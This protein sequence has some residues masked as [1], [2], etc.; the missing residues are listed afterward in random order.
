MQDNG[1]CI[2]HESPRHVFNGKLLEHGR[3]DGLYEVLYCPSSCLLWW[4]SGWIGQIYT[5][6]ATNK[7]AYCA[8]TRICVR[9]HIDYMHYKARD[10]KAITGHLIVF[11]KVPRPWKWD[12]EEAEGDRLFEDYINART[13][14][15]REETACPVLII[16]SCPYAVWLPMCR[17]AWY[18]TRIYIIIEP[19]TWKIGLQF[20]GLEKFVV[21]MLLE[22]LDF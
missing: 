8:T 3:F 6:S 5:I 19:N 14:G 2:M 13:S 9:V 1:Y 4:K 15:L 7:V 12:T 18:L 22:S 21:A 16:I 11:L 10:E 20:K 17:A